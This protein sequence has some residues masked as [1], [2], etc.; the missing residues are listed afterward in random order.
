MAILS[1]QLAHFGC[2]PRE[3]A[4][5]VNCLKHPPS[6]IQEIARRLQFNRVTVHSA[7]QQ[8][9]E[10]GLLTET[11]EG[12]RRFII[13]E[14]PEALFRL[15]QKKETEIALAKLSLESTVKALSQIQA[16]HSGAPI[17][18]FYRGT[19]GLKQ[20]LEETLSAK[21]EVF[22]FN[23]ILEF[24]KILTKEYLY[25]YYERRAAKGIR[26]RLIWPD[27]SFAKNL[28]KDAKKFLLE[29]RTVPEKTG[30]KVGIFCWNDCVAI[31]TLE[32]NELTCTIIQSNALSQ[33]YRTAI[34]ERIWRNSKII[35]V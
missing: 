29:I 3:T 12:K 22:V 33:F 25:K 21:N 20:L 35:N 13:A 32:E 26:S 1:D 31:K 24:A 6:S 15:M 18:R 4:I 17:L 11:R 8:L 7:V 16:V 23:D 2:N 28:S 34:F 30:W 5:Y 10:K 27:C 19:E 14:A 9:L